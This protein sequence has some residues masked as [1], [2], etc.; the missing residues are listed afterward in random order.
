ML[1]LHLRLLA[2]AALA[3]ALGCGRVHESAVF[4]RVRGSSVVRVPLRVAPG[5]TLHLTASAIRWNGSPVLHLWDP[6]A[7]REV[8]RASASHWLSHSARLQYRNPQSSTRQYWAILHSSD[9]DGGGSFELWRDDTRLGGVL[10]VH[11]AALRV[12][13]GQGYVYQAVALPGGPRQASLYALDDA[14]HL[15][16]IAD[17]GGPLGLPRLTAH[18]SVHRL[19]VAAPPSRGPLAVYANDPEDHDGDGLGR[20]LEAELGTCDAADDTHCKNSLLAAYYGAVR[21]GTRDSDRDGL[22]DDA[23]LFGVAADPPLDLPRWGA[24]PRHKDVFVEVDRHT[25]AAD[26]GLSERDYVQIARF[27]SKASGV[28]LRNP[29]GQAGVQ[30]HFDAGFSPSDPQHAA[31]VGDWGGGHVTS[32]SDYRKARSTDFTASRRGYFR[33]ALLTRSG[34]GQAFHDALTINR[35]YHRVSVFAHELAHTL[36][37]GHEGHPSWGKANCKPSYFSLMN[38]VFQNRDDIGFARRAGVALN[39]RAVLETQGLGAQPAAALRESPFELDVIAGRGVDWNR[40]GVISNEPVRAGLL[41]ATYKSCGSSTMARTTLASSG[42]AAAAPTLLTRGFLLFVFFLGEHGQLLTRS[43][44]VSGPDA[45]G[46]CPLGDSEAA[47]CMSFSPPRAVAGLFGLRQIAVLGLSPTRSALGYVDASSRL[48][49]AMLDG[50]AELLAVESDQIIP[51]A[52]TADA[53][54]LAQVQLDENVYGA[55]RALGVWYRAADGGG[56]LMQ[57]LAADGGGPWYV[58]AAQADNGVPIVLGT[59]PS[60]LT[61]GTG[62]LCGVFPDAQRYL[63]L[64]CYQPARDRW[65]D[66]SARAF[67]EGLGPQ[68]GGPVGL[69]FHRYRDAQGQPLLGDDSRGAVYLSFTEPAPGT[70][71]PADN[72]HLLISQWLDAEHGA[73]EQIDFRWRGMLENQW[74]HLAAGTSVR[75]YEDPSLSALKATMLLHTKEGLRVDFLP[76]VDGA[77][78]AQLS[79]GSDFDVMERGICTGLHG[80]SSCGDRTTAAY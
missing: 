71:A 28:Q 39:P 67:Y 14:D 18:A 4:G 29:D 22:P 15:L 11:G 24:D 80:D 2:C 26:A 69:A 8:A 64:H 44:R 75:L 1:S 58:R 53:P 68:T 77:F 74:T 17:G 66:L 10:R 21:T 43:G 32:T 59:G 5:A 42:L 34:T 16:A 20:K 25:A 6:A 50:T 48:H 9:A 13:H 70:S 3:C 46:S 47:G 61:L 62:E 37:L 79:G 31:L 27:Y 63:R 45:H 30:L 19:L 7:G 55:N 76:L 12:A 36:G 73:F 33:Y 78:D 35:D 56:R 54:T 38:Y 60:V 51:G 41:F 40:D 49:V 23:E 65:V 72:P 57:A 52:V